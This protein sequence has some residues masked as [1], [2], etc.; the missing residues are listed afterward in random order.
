MDQIKARFEQ[1]LK[2]R[3]SQSSTPK[4]YLSDINIFF[5][6]VGYKP[7]EEVTSADID[8]FIDHQIAAGLSPTTINRRVCCIRSFFEF[9]IL[10][11][12]DCGKSNPAIIRRHYLKTGTRLPRDASDG[13]VAKT[14][15]VI[16]KE[17]DRACFGLMVG[18]GL[19]V[20]E[21]VAL[22]LGDIEAPASPNVLTKIRICGKGNKE[23][24]VWLTQSI[25]HALQAWIE[26]RPKSSSEHVFLNWRGKP[27][28]VSGIQYRLSL[29]CRAAGVEVS[30]HQL[31]HTFAR[32]LVEGGLPVDSLAKLLGHSHLH[33]TQR[34]IDGADPTVRTDFAAAMARLETILLR[35]QIT[36]P[37]PPKPIPPRK[38]VRAS[39]D[40]LAKL[41][42]QLVD[43]SLPQ[44]VQ[45]AL[46]AYISWRWP[47][48]Q[49]QTAYRL[50][51]NMISTIRRIWKWIMVHRDVKGWEDF[52][53][54]DLE[55]WL[56][57][58][59]QESVSQV[60]IQNNIALMRMLLRFLEMRDYPID[61]GLF[62]VEPP[63][64]E[65]I[66]LPRY[67]PEP[68]YR[69]LEAKVLEMTKANTYTACFDR[70]WFL[71]LAHTGVRLSEMLALG[72]D[73][74]D[75]TAERAI[76]HG[77]KPGHDRVVFLTPAL[78]EAINCYLD[79]RP[80]LLDE[81]RVFVLRGRSPT[82]R[83]IQ[84]RLKKYGRNAGVVVSPHKL[85]HT[86]ATRLL[87]QGMPIHSLRKLL[88]HQHLNTT[89]IYARI[90]DQTL[91]RQFR[92]ATAR[93]E[94]FV[95]DDWPQSSAGASLRLE[96]EVAEASIS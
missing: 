41:L 28:T 17:H 2:R 70:A 11:K 57:A 18:A 48:W 19:R 54:S 7:P 20:G 4:H 36:Q 75:L 81:D 95:V 89:Q 93:L 23:R 10:D 58:R 16:S 43:S 85:R 30:C 52:R 1:Y 62:R 84:R 51:T 13:D 65:N 66:S 82:P 8:A 12:P 31:R 33:T 94:G 67:L 59:C 47:T 91:Y 96:M 42:G 72:V 55:A 27:I 73:D 88:G 3:F 38:P 21:V 25:W 9:F 46:E 69:R 44:W 15:A 49:A 50:G 5:R 6:T 56:Q 80:E 35:D 45:E 29:L 40:Q 83:T 71:T 78:I 87:N 90:Y 68:D 79:K 14:F 64:K 63:K 61:P 34:Y 39:Q 86:L 22:K 32:R 60:T 92:E 37:E 76:V 74:L 77:G 53:K 24:I 26:K